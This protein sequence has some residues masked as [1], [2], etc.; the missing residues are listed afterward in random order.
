MVW[1]TQQVEGYILERGTNITYLVVLLVAET[2]PF[3]FLLT[4]AQQECHLLVDAFCGILDLLGHHVF[5]VQ[6]LCCVFQQFDGFFPELHIRLDIAFY[7]RFGGTAATTFGTHGLLGIKDGV[8]FQFSPRCE[9]G[10]QI[11]LAPR[12]IHHEVR[13]VV[14]FLVV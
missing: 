8:M 14:V 2:L 3:K 10:I 12:R 11:L 1:H 6:Q 7:Q 13:C 5:V 9:G 4:D